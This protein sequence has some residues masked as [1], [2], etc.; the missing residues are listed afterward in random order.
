MVQTSSPPLARTEA[1]DLARFLA[2][3]GMMSSHLL[4][5]DTPAWA[6][7]LSTGLPST[8][9][10]VLAGM[11]AVLSTR[12][13][14]DAGRHLAA[15]LSLATRGLVVLAAGLALERLP[16]GIMIVL[17][18]LGTAL[19]LTACLLRVRTAWL[20]TLAVALA[21]VGPHLS[22]LLRPEPLGAAQVA[23]AVSAVQLAQPGFWAD[24]L[25]VGAYPVVTWLVYVLIGVVLARGLRAATDRDRSGRFAVT[26]AAG[27]AAVLAAA[28]VVSE[29]EWGQG[30]DLALT[31]APHSG[32]TLDI[33]RTSAFAA[34]VIGV[35]LLAG[36]SASRHAPRLRT[37]LRPVLRPVLVA[38]AIPLTGYA[39][40]VV[41]HSLTSELTLQGVDMSQGFDPA[42]LPWYSGGLA[43]FGLHVGGLLLLAT[44]LAV[45]RRRG[46]LEWLVG[47][48]ARA[49]AGIGLS[50]RTPEVMAGT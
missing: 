49:A 34:V 37:I 21:I 4:G 19:V 13:Y 14:T 40:H 28:S 35:L 16:T 12:R 5:P 42:S 38:G 24:L 32:T 3:V 46:P 11:S 44:L 9:F 22:A 25:L 23:S 1:L 29:Q 50:R 18:A 45:V 48:L 20:A 6:A 27:G 2:I 43:I 39:L 26:V 33:A 8:L 30:W 36:R 41:V 31:A 7:F 15:A 10:A 17:P 47:R